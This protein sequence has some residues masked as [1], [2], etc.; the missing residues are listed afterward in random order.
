MSTGPKSEVKCLKDWQYSHVG[1]QC[2]TRRVKHRP[3]AWKY[4]ERLGG[5]LDPMALVFQPQTA[6]TLIKL[7]YFRRSRFQHLQQPLGHNTLY[8]EG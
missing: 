8:C 2:F 6:Q 3:N 7:L 4:P 5:H 1:W